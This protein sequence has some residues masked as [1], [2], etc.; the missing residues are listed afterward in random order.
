MGKPNNLCVWSSAPIWDETATPVAPLMLLSH[1]GAVNCVRWS[2]NGTYL[3]SA[4]DD[5]TVVVWERT[6]SK[7][8]PL[9]RFEKHEDTVLHVDWRHDDQQLVSA[10]A[11]HTVM[12]W[13]VFGPPTGGDRL[14]IVL[15]GHTDVVNGCAF[16]GDNR[17]VSQAND[18]TLR[19]WTADA[20]AD[21]RIKAPFKHGAYTALFQRCA[22]SRDGGTILAVHAFNGGGSTVQ[23]I[24][25]LTVSPTTDFVGFRKPVVVVVSAQDLHKTTIALSLS[26]YTYT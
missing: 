18:Q 22:V 12:I 8:A 23:A 9:F 13:R 15:R 24:D 5:A 19:V 11:D 7:F 25:A 3:A 21:K 2:H 20:S 4:G 1:Q 26:S 6:G 16:L 10:S 14:L 17:V